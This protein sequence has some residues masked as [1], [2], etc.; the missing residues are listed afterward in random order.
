MPIFWIT[1]IAYIIVHI[2][3]SGMLGAFVYRLRVSASL[4]HTLAAF[5]TGSIVLLPP[6][7]LPTWGQWISWVLALAVAG[8]FAIRPTNFPSRLWSS[9][10]ALGYASLAMGLIALWGIWDG[11]HSPTF[12]LSGM[13]V[14]AS[15]LAWRR[16]LQAA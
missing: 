14:L 9:D 11:L 7:S 4:S 10:F 6:L 3:F 12:L 5:T 2:G 16:G 8:I 15:L 1:V 13:A